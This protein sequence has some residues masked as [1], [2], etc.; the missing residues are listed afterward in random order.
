MKK[1][2]RK[3][4]GVLVSAAPLA[5]VSTASHAAID[6]TAVTGAITEAGTAVGVIGAAILVLTVGIKVYK[7]MQRAL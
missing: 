3:V 7:W 4:A 6:T 1:Y 2:L 5:L